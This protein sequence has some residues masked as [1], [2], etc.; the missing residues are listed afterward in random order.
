MRFAFIYTELFE[1]SAA[2]LL[3]DS[4]MESVESVLCVNPRAGDV[5]RDTNGGANSVLHYLV[6]ASGGQRV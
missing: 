1:K 3:T 2:D 4:I 5:I 6:E